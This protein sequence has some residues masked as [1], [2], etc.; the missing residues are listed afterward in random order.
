MA[1]LRDYTHASKTFVQANYSYAPKLKFLFHTYFDINPQA[2]PKNVGTGDNFGLAVKTVRLPSYSFETHV[3]NQYNRKRIVQTKIKYDNVNISFH[4]DNN[5][6]IRGLWE[7]YYTYYYKD[8]SNPKTV[9]AGARGGAPTAQVAGGGTTAT[10][11]LADYNNRTQYTPNITGN[12]D[13]GYLG[14]MRNS[15]SLVKIPFF[16]NITVFGFNQHNF[17]AYTLINPLITRFSHDTYDYAQGNGTMEMVMD[18]D[19]ETV[20]YNEGALDGQSPENIVT[21]FG[22]VQHYDRQPGPGTLPGQN[23]TVITPQGVVPGSGGFM[24]PKG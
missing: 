21:G 14:E 3:M 8:G 1:T 17:V 5:N 15:T 16:K 24:Y 18:I 2:Y 4:D 7:A 6:R 12:N 23:S 19:Y 22:A 10:P 9:F 11:T 13:W 20:V